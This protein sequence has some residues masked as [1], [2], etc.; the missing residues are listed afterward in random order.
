MPLL[1]KLSILKV[2]RAAT[3]CFAALHHFETRKAN[4]DK[5]TDDPK[6]IEEIGIHVLY[7]KI[8]G[9]HTECTKPGRKYINF[10]F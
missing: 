10:K 8:K 2:Y 6:Y 4:D 1:S 5:Q 9:I 3:T 7:K